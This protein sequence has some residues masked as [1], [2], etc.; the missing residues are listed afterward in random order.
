[1]NHRL[2][3]LFSAMVAG[4]VATPAP[5]APTPPAP[6]PPAPTPPPPAAPLNGATFRVTSSD[7]GTRNF[8]KGESFAPGEV[9]SGQDVLFT[10]AT[11]RLVV[12]NRHPDGSVAFGVVV[13]SVAT[14]PSGAVVSMSAGSSPASGSVRTKAMLRATGVTCTFTAVGIGT[15]TWASNSADWENAHYTWYET[16]QGSC[17]YFRK[18][19]GSDPHLVAWLRVRLFADGRYDLQPKIENGYFNVANPG[20]KD[21]VFK[22]SMNGE[23]KFSESVNLLHHL[24]F[25]CINGSHFS[26]WDAAGSAQDVGVLHPDANEERCEGVAQPRAGHGVRRRMHSVRRDGGRLS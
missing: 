7:T 8:Q 5:P 16:D 18:P 1:M 3:K 11:A 13:G 9:P 25:Y 15:A 22:F 12:K 23:E 26:Y 2:L 4:G 10:G 24:H 21:A 14:S 6:T 19:I 20:N 17:W